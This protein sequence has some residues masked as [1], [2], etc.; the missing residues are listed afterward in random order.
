VPVDPAELDAVMV[1]GR[2]V[3]AEG[4]IVITPRI[5]RPIEDVRAVQA[6]EAEERRG[7]RRVA[8]VEADTV[9]LD[10]LRQQERQA[11]QERQQQPAQ[12]ARA[13]AALDRRVG[14]SA[15]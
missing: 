10:R 11:E 4:R 6:G 8:R 12:Q 14:P 3:A 9:V 13:V 1:L 2:E 15:S 5:V 7:E